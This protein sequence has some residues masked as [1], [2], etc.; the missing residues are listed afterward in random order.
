MLIKFKRKI[1]S[2]SHFFWL[3]LLITIII[4][5]TNLQQTNKNSQY[6]SLKKTLNNFYLQKAFAKITSGLEYRFTEFEYV[7]QEG[8]SFENIINTIEISKQEKKILLETIIK[9]KK[10]KTKSKNLF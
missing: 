1:K 8:D 9:N 6:L 3:I 5:V 4:F 2:L 7:V 10:I